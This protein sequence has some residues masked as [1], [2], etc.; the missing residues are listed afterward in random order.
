MTT[1]AP[2]SHS[3]MVVGSWSHDKIVQACKT[4][5]PVHTQ[6]CEALARTL[7]GFRRYADWPVALEPGY[8]ENSRIRCCKFNTALP[9]ELVRAVRASQVNSCRTSLWVGL[10]GT[11][12]CTVF[13]FRR[14]FVR[15][16]QHIFVAGGLGVPPKAAV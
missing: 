7:W 3:R 1:P 11:S 14:A 10:V 9:P 4:L 6:V 2:L 12:L 5:L 16:P 8:L 13:S 15:L